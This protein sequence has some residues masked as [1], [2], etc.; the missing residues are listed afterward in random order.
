MG[1]NDEATRKISLIDIIWVKQNAPVCGLRGGNDY[2]D[3]F[4]HFAN[5]QPNISG[6]SVES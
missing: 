4:W 3:L 2:V 6:T 5:V 1:L